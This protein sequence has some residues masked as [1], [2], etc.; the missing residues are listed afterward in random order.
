MIYTLS[1]INLDVFGHL[2]AAETRCEHNMDV[3][4]FLKIIS[5]Q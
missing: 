4:S 3:L 5:E 2:G 1:G